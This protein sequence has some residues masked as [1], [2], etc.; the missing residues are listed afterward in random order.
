[1]KKSY[2]EQILEILRCV[3]PAQHRQMKYRRKTPDEAKAFFWSHV[4]IGLP[5]ECWEWQGG[6]T[7]V[8]NRKGNV[9]GITSING[10]AML[11]HRFAYLLTVGKLKKR[12]VICHGCD[13]YLCCN[14]AHLNQGPHSQNMEEA[15]ERGLIEKGD[16]SSSRRHP[17]LLRR[18]EASPKASL[19]TLEVHIIRWLF[20]AGL[21]SPPLLA[22]IYNV[23]AV[24]INLIV[25]GKSWQHVDSHIDLSPAKKQMLD[26]FYADHAIENRAGRKINDWKQIREIR[27]RHELGWSKSRIAKFY[28][29][30]A[31]HISRVVR[32]ETWAFVQ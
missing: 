18:G 13:N 20:Y 1:M 29:L 24:Q 3:S 28:G 32:G 19:T 17:E 30:S 25:T 15:K 12:K 26:R 22:R 14:P 31:S 9:Y 5:E 7:P 11:A 27:L 8:G 23:S 21:A 4:R 6:T 16:Q 10:K 2:R